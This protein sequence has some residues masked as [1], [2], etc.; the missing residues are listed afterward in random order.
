MRIWIERCESLPL[1][2]GCSLWFKLW[3]CERYPENRRLARQTSAR[4]RKLTFQ[5]Q[6][7]KKSPC[8]GRE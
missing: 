6:L 1:G 7:L 5:R 4:R 8:C 3:R 2:M